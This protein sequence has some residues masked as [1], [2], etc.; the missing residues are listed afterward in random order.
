M[1]NDIQDKRAEQ[2]MESEVQNESTGQTMRS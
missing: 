2:I 1:R